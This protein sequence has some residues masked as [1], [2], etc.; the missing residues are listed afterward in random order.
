MC[1]GWFLH[2][3]F[4]KHSRERNTTQYWN[5]GAISALQTKL[6]ENNQL[7]KDTKEQANEAA[8]SLKETEKDAKIMANKYDGRGSKT[9]VPPPPMVACG[10]GPQNTQLAAN[11]VGSSSV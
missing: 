5:T 10:V 9:L 8:K 6:K 7:L 2:R 11:E 3:S 4:T 1:S